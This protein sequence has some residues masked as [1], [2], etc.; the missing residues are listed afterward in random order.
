MKKNHDHG[1]KEALFD[2]EGG[3]ELFADGHRAARGPANTISDAP[4]GRGKL[5]ARPSRSWP[6]KRFRQKQALSEREIKRHRGGKFRK[7]QGDMEKCLF[8]GKCAF[9][10]FRGA[11][12]KRKRESLRSIGREGRCRSDRL[13]RLPVVD[14]DRGRQGRLEEEG[15][16]KIGGEGGEYKERGAAVKIHRKGGDPGLGRR[17]KESM[18]TPQATKNSAKKGAHLCQP[19]N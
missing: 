15:R 16:A 2:R 19:Y 6:N 13:L 17:K 5:E 1:K 10:D 12:G 9:A 4:A 11:R 7:G 18:G 3:G 14:K 8:L